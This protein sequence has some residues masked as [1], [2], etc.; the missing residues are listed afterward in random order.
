M[1][2]TTVTQE[3]FAQGLAELLAKK[4]ISMAAY[5]QA[6]EKT[7]KALDNLVKQSLRSRNWDKANRAESKEL[8]KA[9]FAKVG[10]KS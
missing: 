4:G 7:R 8:T 10:K 1:G 3:Q 5:R 9:F 2:K 6:D